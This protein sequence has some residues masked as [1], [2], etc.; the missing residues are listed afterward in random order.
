VGANIGYYTILAA[1]RVKKVY[2][3]EPEQK[4]FEILKKNVEENN[5]KNVVL[6]NKAA[7]D[8]REKKYLVRDEENLGNSRISVT[9]NEKVDTRVLTETLDNLLINEQYISLIKV[10]TQGWEPEVIS[11]T[12][13]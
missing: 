2:A 10:D 5:L 12:K 11:G 6:I 4:C 1:E 13:K 7:S 3:I 9:R 8:K